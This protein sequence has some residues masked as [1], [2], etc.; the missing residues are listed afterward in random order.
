MY[1]KIVGKL[2][3]TAPYATTILADPNSLAGGYDFSPFDATLPSDKGFQANV[4]QQLFTE[5]VNNPNTL[6]LLNLN[7]IKL[8]NHIAEL[9]GIKNLQ[10]FSLTAN[11]ALPPLQ[12]SVQP[13][14]EVGAQAAAGTAQPVPDASSLISE[15]AKG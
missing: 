3:L 14:A 13:N 10:D 5:L 6:Q 11:P 1:E 8:L 12:A 9:Y 2:A 15:L 7:P 4:F